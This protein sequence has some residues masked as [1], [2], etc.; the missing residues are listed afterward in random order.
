MKIL[1]AEDDMH[2]ASKLVRVLHEDNFAVDA[3]HN[4]PDALHLGETGPYDCCVLDIGLPQI[5]GLQVLRQWRDQGREFPVLVLTAR[6]A[7]A[8]KAAAFK[9]GA[10]D[11]LTKPFLPQELVVRLRALMRRARGQTSAPVCCGDLAYHP[12]TG[13]FRFKGEPLR[14]TAYESRILSRL[15]QF[16]E[17]VVERETLFESVYEHVA[18][19]PVNSL[20]VLI[21][22][23]RRKIGPA[24][25]ET[26]RG[27]GYRL[28]AGIAV[29]AA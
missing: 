16:R 12:T 27:H 28:T 13:D 24:M 19:V 20:E 9:A 25:I 29:G 5:D 8:D 15:I 3:V 17:S 6:D 1:L 2:L 21:G 18:E 22:R 11:Y 14:L 4:G 26:A 23:L 7:W 10:D